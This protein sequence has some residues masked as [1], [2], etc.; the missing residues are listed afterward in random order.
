MPKIFVTRK[1]PTKGIDL[2]K[3]QGYDID[4]SGKDGVLTREEFLKVLKSEKYDAV[5]C[6]LTDKIDREVFEATPNTKIFANYAVGFDNIDLV[7]AKKRGIVISNTPEVL[8]DAVAEF[9]MTLIL[10]VAKRVIEADTFTKAGK[11]EGWA[12]ELLLGNELKGK[13]LGVVGTGR[14]G[15]RVIHHAVRGFDMNVIYYD[16][17]E[18]K[19]IE[20]DYG[21]V[22]MDKVDDVLK[23]ADVVSIH[24]PLLDSTRHLINK[25]KLMLMKK[26]AVLI[27]TSR[28]PVIDEK[29]LVEVLK[30][31][32]LRGV[33]LDV[34]EFEPKLAEGL[35][36][37]PNV[38]L[39][40][41]IASAT[42]EA[43]DAMSE[44]AAKNIIAVLSGGEALNPVEAK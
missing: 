39:T 27:N 25:E 4:I 13:T 20:K 15:S 17:A 9:A 41:H 34:F 29:A 2:L 22:Y 7:E 21:A 32:H 18:N 19:Q 3:A 28:G 31:G 14:I 23:N 11:Y 30:S 12:P 42:E 36:D 40:P 38:V 10:T 37:L 16:V 44:I 43:R 26:K 1:I 24:V 8:T 35:K 6:L 5:L 33:G